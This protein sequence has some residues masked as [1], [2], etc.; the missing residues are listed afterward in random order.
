MSQKPIQKVVPKKVE[1]V[2]LLR[3]L[4]GD[5]GPK[6][7]KGEKG[8]RGE[9][10]KDGTDGIDG[11][12]GEDGKDGRDGKDGLNGRDGINGKDGKRGEPGP[13]GDRGPQ[14]PKGERGYTGING[15]DG[16]DG[17]D[18]QDGKDGAIPDHEIDRATGRIRFKRPDGTWGAWVEIKQRITQSGGGGD[19]LIHAIDD[20]KRIYNRITGIT[21]DENGVDYIDFD[22]Q[23]TTVVKEGRVRWNTDEGTL[24]I[25][26]PG[27]TVNQQIGMEVF[28]PRKVQNKTG[29]DLKNGDLIYISGGTG[30]NL[31]IAKARADAITTARPTIAMLTEDIDNNA[32]GFA[33]TFGIVR[34]ET[35]QPIDTTSYNVG[36]TLYL[37]ETT[38]GAFTSTVPP[39]PNYVV[40]VGYVFRKHATEGAIF[41]KI[42]EPSVANCLAG[43]ESATWKDENFSGAMTALGASAPD[44]ITINGTGILVTAF[45]GVSTSEELNSTVELQ[46]D[47]LEGSDIYPHAHIGATTSASGVI[48]LFLEY[49][50]TGA[51]S[52]TGTSEVRATGTLSSTITIPADNQWVNRYISFGAIDCSSCKNGDQISMR[53]YRIPGDAEDTYGAD[54][55]I[56]TWGYHYQVDSVGT[57]NMATKG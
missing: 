17:K 26:M 22:T 29:S 18:G 39:H 21:G 9:P 16:K 38:D 24:S 25:G 23:T 2:Q 53:L 41:V 56:R 5:Q 45:D 40:K 15:R 30:V 52:E 31:Y 54:N 7:E 44:L 32:F 37:S 1:K 33:T 34:G 43:G 51:S 42:E 12:D 13:K 48:K 28:I 47:Y 10:G 35:S 8:E 20:I 3:G 50:I 55:F 49:Y 4:V 19:I 11:L 27:G 6:G 14:G 46:H 57:R 36:D